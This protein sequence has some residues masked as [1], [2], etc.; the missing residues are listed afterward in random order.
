M[1]RRGALFAVAALLLHAGAAIAQPVA[2]EA[3]KQHFEA[4]LEQLRAQQWSLAEAQFRSSLALVP[5]ASTE[6]DLAFVLFKQGKLRES[7][8]RLQGLLHSEHYADDARYIPAAQ[9]LL[10]EVVA[11]LST[12]QLDIDPPNAQLSI[13]GETIAA[14]GSARAV[15][16]DPGLHHIELSADGFEAQSLDISTDAHA[17]TERE[18]KLARATPAPSLPPAALVV[19]PAAPAPVDAWSQAGPWIVIGL[20]AA[21]LVGAGVTGIMAARD[22]AAF[23]HLCPSH[24]ACDP[25]LKGLRG[26]VTGLGMASDVLLVSGAAIT[27]GGVALRLMVDARSPDE[28]R[29]VAVRAVATLRY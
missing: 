14:V 9:A 21:L 6:Y 22:D 11:Q 10:A 26:Q 8:E 17:Q 16:L 27:V 3:A 5:R 15:S 7:S 19:P 29:S 28:H 13:D 18:I 12:L 24:S 23:K 25:Q 2:A 20:G 4:G 1:V